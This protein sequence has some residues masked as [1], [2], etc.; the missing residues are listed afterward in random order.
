MAK[1]LTSHIVAPKV[2]SGYRSDRSIVALE[3]RGPQKK[4]G[5]DIWKFNDSLF[6]EAMYDKHIVEVVI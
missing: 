6:D 1:H 3:I 5:S 2:I 4:G